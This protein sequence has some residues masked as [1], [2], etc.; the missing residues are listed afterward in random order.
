MNRTRNTLAVL[1]V[2]LVSAVGAASASAATPI[3]KGTVGP[4]FT[5]TL[6]KGGKKVV[7]LRAG[8]YRI[9]VADKSGI[10]DFHLT[11]KGL[12]K[13]TSVAG[14]GTKTWTVKLRKGTYK[15]VCD[16]HALAMKGSFTVK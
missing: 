7:S 10:H 9:V 12:N 5:I 15:Y 3:L 11:G 14:K 6:T 2:T 16:P 13:T 4:G 8:T 1:A